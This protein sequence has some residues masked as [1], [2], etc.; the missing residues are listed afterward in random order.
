MSLQYDQP[1]SSEAVTEVISNNQSIS[2]ETQAA[3]TQILGLSGRSEVVVASLDASGNLVAPGGQA[4]ELVLAN[5]AGNAGE[6]VEVSLPPEALSSTRAWVFNSEADLALRFNTVERVIVTGNGNDAIIVNG[7]K[8]T[9]VDAGNGNDTIETTGGN[10]LITGGNGSDSISSGAGSDTIISGTG[11]DTIDGG[12]GRDV[13]TFTGSVQD[14]TVAVVNGALVVTSK[15]DASNAATIRNVEFISFDNGQAINVAAN[16]TEATVLRLYQGILNR[17]AEKGGADYWIN[18]LTSK[19]ASLSSIANSFL[20]SAELSAKGNLNN[21]QFVE[22]L[23]Q[24]ALGRNPEEEGKAYWLNLLDNGQDRA[25]VAVGIVG[26]VEATGYV[27]NVQIIT[28][29]V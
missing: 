9:T 19:G 27:V 18:E 23:Y 15:A 6:R 26:S 14:Y 29:L 21:E 24:N 8:N 28:G 13:V 5:I 4:P 11:S 12:S 25:D 16:S 10:D 2:T 22:M 3:I 20:N 1:I 17:D 7:D